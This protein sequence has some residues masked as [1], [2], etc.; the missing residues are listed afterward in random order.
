VLGADL[1]EGGGLEFQHLGD[2]GR[3]D[4]PGPAAG[5]HQQSLGDG[6]RER[7]VDAEGGTTTAVGFHTEAAADGGR[8]ALDHIHAH[9]T[10]GDA[11]QGGGAEAGQEDE[12]G[13]ALVVGLFVGAEQAGG[14]RV[15]A[16]RIEIQTGAVVAEFDH[17]FVAFVGDAQGDLAD[18]GLA[19]GAPGVG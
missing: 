2:H 7:Q 9:A 14:D 13:Q 6:Q 12:I 8:F 19:G 16:D 3:G 11:G 10:A 5:T 1:F 18:L 4:R 17:H 15:G